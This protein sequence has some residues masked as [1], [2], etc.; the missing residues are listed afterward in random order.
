MV[1]NSITLEV[2]EVLDSI[3]RRGSFAGAAEE[4]NKATSAIS[5]SI[6]KLEDQLALSIFVRQGRR[7]VLTPAGRAVLEDGRVIL[8]ASARLADKAKEIASGWEP[9]LRI[10][11][12][13]IVNHQVFFNVLATFQNDHSNLE[14][15]VRETVLNGG[16]ET[17]E[18]DGV[19]ILVGATGPVPKHKGFRSVSIGVCDLV[20][21]ISAGHQAVKD[22]RGPKRTD[23]DYTSLRTVV[24]H[25]TANE[26]V[27]RSAGLSGSSASVLYVQTVD[28]K[29]EAILAGM[30][31]GH[32]PR[33]RIRHH[34]KEGRLIEL[35]IEQ[36]NPECFIAWKLANKGRAL[37]SISTALISAGFSLANPN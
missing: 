7:S 21:V 12:E 14:I 23:F 30:G 8:D 9:R 26:H 36:S 31:I 17:L 10:G 34:I 20:P 28:Q 33:Y 24:S 29:V 1:N 15:D 3:D 11:V 5:Y 19:D 18:L 27:A 4:L 35:T 32:L 25:D 6:Q 2:L 22:V 13:S 16:W 37:A